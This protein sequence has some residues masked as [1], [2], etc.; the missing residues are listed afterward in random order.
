MKN[1][2]NLLCVV[3]I[4]SIVSTKNDKWTQKYKHNTDTIYIVPLYLHLKI[5]IKTFYSPPSTYRSM[6]SSF[7]HLSLATTSIVTGVGFLQSYTH[8]HCQC[9]LQV[10]TSRHGHEEMVGRQCCE[11]VVTRWLWWSEGVSGSVREARMSPTT[12]WEITDLSSSVRDVRMSSVAWERTDLRRLMV[13]SAVL[14]MTVVLW[15]M[16]VLA[17]K[18]DGG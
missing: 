6:P 3:E 13:V 5:K 2:Y 17:C 4:Q 10:R 15:M 7:T 11:K 8:R 18:V 9:H 12:A 1:W 14:R 16:V